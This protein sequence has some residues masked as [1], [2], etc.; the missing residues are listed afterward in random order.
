ME[1]AIAAGFSNLSEAITL[2]WQ[3]FTQMAEALLKTPLFLVPLAIFV[4]GA[5][6]GLVKR[7]L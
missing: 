6:I 2:I 5:A 4:V 7:I 1:G 3:Q